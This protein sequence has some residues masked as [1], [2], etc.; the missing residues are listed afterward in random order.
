MSNI[1][2]LKQRIGSVIKTKKMTQ[3]MKMVAAAKFKRATAKVLKMKGYTEGLESILEDLLS[4]MEPDELPDL[5]LGNKGNKQAVLIVS[6]DRGLCGG[7][8]SGILRYA[9]AYLKQQNPDDVELYL[10]GNK[11][12]SYFK[13]KQWKIAE[14]FTY[15]MGKLELEKVENALD[16][17]IQRY[18]NEEIGSVKIFFNQFKSAMNS[19][20]ANKQYLPF[21]I[22]EKDPEQTEFK[23]DY[24]YEHS[25]KTVIES[26]LHQYLIMM[27]FK[28]L[29]DSNAGEESARMMS[30][31]SATGNAAEMLDKLKLIYNRT[32][33]A[34]ITREISEIVSGV[35]AMSH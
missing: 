7:F 34:N 16:P 30:M 24:I 8:N 10:L 35:E 4:R 1:R 6:G 2:E 9:E 17:I 32:R 31:E 15:F 29:L 12:C 13:N 3:A 14:S 25:K 5:L 19:E 27:F 28:N 18:L 23:S 26:F 33:Q 20:I 22:P 21:E 11:A